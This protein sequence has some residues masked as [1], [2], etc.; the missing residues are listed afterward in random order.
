MRLS[1]LADIDS[2]SANTLK[3]LEL[4]SKI[5]SDEDFESLMDTKFTTILS[6]TFEYELKPNGETSLVN[7]SNFPEYK[8]LVLQA[9][10]AECSLQVKAV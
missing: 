2:I 6:N 1:D 10:L 9:R 8:K 4:A 7:S 5:Y 3:D